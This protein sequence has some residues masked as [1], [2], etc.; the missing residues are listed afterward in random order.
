MKNYYYILGLNNNAS[1]SEIKIAYRKLSMKFHPDKNDGD[2][3][4]TKHFMEIQEAYEVLSDPVRKGEYD[5]F[6]ETKVEKSTLIKTKVR[7]ETYLEKDGN[8][9]KIAI[10][11]NVLIV[12]RIILNILLD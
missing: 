10:W 9:L 11:L 5:Q 7:H 6:H 3:Y 2:N 4:F 8:L 1:L 12:I